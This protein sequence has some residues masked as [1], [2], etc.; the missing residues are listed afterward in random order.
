MNLKTVESKESL[1]LVE[2]NEDHWSEIGN[3][4]NTFRYQ[5][6]EEKAR[7]SLFTQVKCIIFGRDPHVSN[8]NRQT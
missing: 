6:T 5:V 1:S 3:W 7:I 4:T 2:S 8:Q